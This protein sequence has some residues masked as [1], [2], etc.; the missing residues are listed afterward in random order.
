MNAIRPVAPVVLLLLLLASC[1][2]DYEQARVAESISGQIPDTILLDFTHTVM[3]GG[4]VWVVL[5]AERAE[6]YNERKEIV[7]HNVL[8]REY[9]QQGGLLTEARA[10]QAVFHTDSEAV[11]ALMGLLADSV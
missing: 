1:S 6:T 7:L 10:E 11:I 5:Q 2:L 3:S 9:D 8:F 4:K